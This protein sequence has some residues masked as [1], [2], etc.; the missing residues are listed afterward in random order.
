LVY[1][2]AELRQC[3]AKKSGSA[4]LRPLLRVKI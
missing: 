2:S 1:V 4:E 3:W